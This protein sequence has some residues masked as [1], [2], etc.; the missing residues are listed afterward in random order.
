MNFTRVG[1]QKYGGFVDGGGL[2]SIARNRQ[3]QA[4]I[5]GHKSQEITASKQR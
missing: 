2:F 3:L 5:M 1:E 4:D